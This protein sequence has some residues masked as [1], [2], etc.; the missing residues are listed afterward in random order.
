MNK[1]N[2]MELTIRKAMTEDFSRVFALFHQL[3]PNKELNENDM[4]KV[5]ERGLESNL[6]HE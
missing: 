6:D 4:R 1:E 3:W 2:D 5:F